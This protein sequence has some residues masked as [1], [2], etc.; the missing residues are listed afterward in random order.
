MVQYLQI[1]KFDIETLNLPCGEYL[2]EPGQGVLD[3]D[4]RVKPL[5]LSG[6]V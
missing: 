3:P 5:T 1:S 2:K 4:T 6:G